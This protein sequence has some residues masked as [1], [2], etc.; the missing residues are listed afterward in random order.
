[1]IFCKLFHQGKSL[2]LRGSSESLT[3][4]FSFTIA[5]KE[6]KDL[7]GKNAT[8]PFPFA[9]NSQEVRCFSNIKASPFLVLIQQKEIH[10]TL[11]ITF[12]QG[13]ALSKLCFEWGLN[14]TGISG[15][16]KIHINLAE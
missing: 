14:Y 15:F 4:N 5:V 6:T 11:A 10:P 12:R 16:S 7:V 2:S 13:H 1:M 8:A 9:I 3:G